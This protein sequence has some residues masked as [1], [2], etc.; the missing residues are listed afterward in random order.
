MTTSK[1][2][3]GGLIGYIPAKGHSRGIPNKN[4][5]PLDGRP[6]LEY[7]LRFARNSKL[8]DAIFVSTDAADIKTVALQ[9]GAQVIDRPPHLAQD[10]T[11][12][13]DVLIYDIPIIE[14]RHGVAELLAC[15][16]P[17]SPLRQLDDMEKAVALA[18]DNPDAPGVVSFGPLP[19]ALEHATALDPKTQRIQP[20]YGNDKL[21]ALS[22]RQSHAKLYYPN[23]AIVVLR[24]DQ[25]KSDP[26]FY[27][28]G[29][30]IGLPVDPIGGL[31]IDTPDD[32]KLAQIIVRGLNSP[33]D[34]RKPV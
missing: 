1:A 12:I 14:Q 6:L 17:T 7:T 20:L 33:G 2:K 3:A 34:R 19:G 22:Q 25:F 28:E 9:F 21:T 30:S 11:R 31:D 4:M 26:R 32:L 15:M 27:V 18:R 29:R 13:A 16:I 23:G 5:A 8:F 10:T 24:I